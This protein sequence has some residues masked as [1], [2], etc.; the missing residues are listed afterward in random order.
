MSFLKNS[1]KLQIILNFIALSVGLYIYDIATTVPVTFL[2]LMN[3]KSIVSA[4]L[5]IIIILLVPAAF[6]IHLFVKKWKQIKHIECI[7]IS[8]LIL[9]E[10]YNLFYKF[11]H[12]FARTFIH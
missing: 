2:A 7:L 3:F 4:P 12:G 5:I 6:L 11:Q 10:F 1:P 8:F 9:L